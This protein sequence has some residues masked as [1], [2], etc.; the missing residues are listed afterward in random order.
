MK[1]WIAEYLARL[2][3]S[4]VMVGILWMIYLIGMAYPPVGLVLLG[5]LLGFVAMTFGGR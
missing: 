4:C 5:V 3:L 1:N 2:A